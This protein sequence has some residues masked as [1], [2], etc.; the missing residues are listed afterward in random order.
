[1]QS[2]PSNE[3]VLIDSGGINPYAAADLQELAGLIRVINAEPLMVM[4]AGGDVYDATEMGMAFRSLG[5]TRLLVTRID[6]VHRLGSVLAAADAAR[7]SFCEV[8][9][10]PQIANGL[11][12]LTPLSLAGLL[13][14]NMAGGP[15]QAVF[16]SPQP[17]RARS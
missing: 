7:L 4:A 1:L 14:P 8:G 3:L 10:S 5:A 13:L 2:S 16:T 9:T 12:A 11:S 6:M 17:R 15:E